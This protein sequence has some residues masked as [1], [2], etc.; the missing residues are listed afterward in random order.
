MRSTVRGV[1]SIL[2]QDLA[3]PQIDA[4]LARA[5]EMARSFAESYKGR[6]ARLSAAELA[7]AFRRQEEITTVGY[8]PLGYASL[9][10]SAQTQDNQ[11]QALLSRVREATTVP[12]NQ[13]VFFDVELK[14]L[15]EERFDALLRA[16]ELAGYRHHLGT[17]R[18]FAPHTLSEPEERLM[19]QMRLTGAP[20][21]SQLYTEVTSSLRFPV[22][23]GGNKVAARTGPSGCW[24]GWG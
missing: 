13:M 7:D 5:G 11:R 19:A 18:T 9:A 20:A 15:P 6:V 14:A 2:Y 17:L 24:R 1:Y 10:F 21:W 16:P 12:S 4:D 23:V 8:K 3:D 22:E